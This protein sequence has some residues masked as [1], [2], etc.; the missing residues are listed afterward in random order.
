[1]SETGDIQVEAVLTPDSDSFCS[2]ILVFSGDVQRKAVTFIDLISGKGR[3]FTEQD[4]RLVFEAGEPV[5]E[6]I[7]VTIVRLPRDAPEVARRD[8][9]A[10]AQAV[11]SLAKVQ[12]QF[13]S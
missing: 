5:E 11:G 7:D 13:Q 8:F 6:E 4:G 9:N 10:M 2:H 3:A 1:M 12:F